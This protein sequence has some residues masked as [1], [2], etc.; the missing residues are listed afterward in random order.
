MAASVPLT[1]SRRP[2]WAAAVAWARGVPEALY[3]NVPIR[4]LRQGM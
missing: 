1:L 3:L 2:I 4:F